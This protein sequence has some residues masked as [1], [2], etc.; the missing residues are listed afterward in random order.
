MTDALKESAIFGLLLLSPAVLAFV[1]C[2]VRG[3][4]AEIRERRELEE[5]RG[6]EYV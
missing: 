5:N 6:F 2:F 4:R 1:V 3:I